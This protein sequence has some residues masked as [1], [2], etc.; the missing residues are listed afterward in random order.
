MFGTLEAHH[1]SDEGRITSA[2]NV[3]RLVFRIEVTVFLNQIIRCPHDSGSPETGQNYNI[4]TKP[5]TTIN[6]LKFQNPRSQVLSIEQRHWLIFRK[7]LQ[8]IL[9]VFIS[10]SK[11]SILIASNHIHSLGKLIINPKSFNVLTT[12]PI[13]AQI[14]YGFRIGRN[15]NLGI[16]GCRDFVSLSVKRFIPDKLN[17]RRYS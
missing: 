4:E 11:F 1:R 9:E 17:H 5:L 8:E 16:Q 10:V 15:I 13:I 2:L 7:L 6:G 3:C 14:F 12:L